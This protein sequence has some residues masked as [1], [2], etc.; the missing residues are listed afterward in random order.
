[1]LVC[2]PVFLHSLLISYCL[3]FGK[4]RRVSAVQH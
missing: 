2:G 4:L 1:M 3:D